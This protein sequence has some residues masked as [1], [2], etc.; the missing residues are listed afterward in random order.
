MI[1]IMITVTVVV[2]ALPY[3]QI[4][5]YSCSKS[6]VLKHVKKEVYKVQHLAYSF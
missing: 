4:L 3:V 1:I 2:F 5:S 6:Y